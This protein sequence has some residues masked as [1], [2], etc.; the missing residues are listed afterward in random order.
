M[1][2]SPSLLVD[3]YSASNG[4]QWEQDQNFVIGL[5]KDHS[6]LVKFSERDESYSRVR[7]YLQKLVSKAVSVIQSRFVPTEHNHKHEKG[8]SQYYEVMYSIS[9][10]EVRSGKSFPPI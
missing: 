4:R 10:L 8:K 3:K 6:N 5:P 9:L 2:G 7:H 1:K